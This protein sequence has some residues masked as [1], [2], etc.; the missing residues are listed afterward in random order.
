MNQLRAPAIPLITID[1]YFSIWSCSDNLYDDSPRHW[2]GVRQNMLGI[3]TIDGESKRFMGKINFDGVRH[4]DIPCL[5]QTDIKITPLKTTYVFEDEKIRLQLEFM[6]T[7]FLDDLKL[8]SRPV[9]YISYSVH[10][11]DNQEHI[12]EI[13]ICISAEAAVDQN[14]Q[15][16]SVKKYN[17]GACCGRGNKDILCISGDDRRIDWGWL[18]IFAQNN[19]IPVIM[20]MQNLALKYIR[21][22]EAKEFEKDDEFAVRDEWVSIG[23]KRDFTV[24]STDENGFI[25]IA[26][27]DIHS[28]MYFEKPIDAYYKK[29]GDTFD[30][31]CKKAL[32]EYDM[33]QKKANDFD[34]N[35]IIETNKI[36]KKYSDIISLSYRQA[37][38]AHKITWDG[39]EIQFFSKECFSNGCI[40]TVDVTYP[41]IP[42]FLLY[43]PDLVCGMLNPIFKYAVSHKWPYEF[44]PHDVG[45]YPLANGQVYGLDSSTGKLSL[46]M[47]MPIEECGNILIC[48]DALCRA[49][50]DFSYANKNLAIIKQWAEYLISHGFDPENQLCTDDFAG[51][52]A[53]N[54]NLSIK[55]ILGIACFGDILNR[56]GHQGEE[57]IKIARKFA[58]KWKKDAFEEDHYKLAFD[59]D[60]SWSIKYNLVWDKLLNLNIFDEDIFETELNYYAGKIKKYG[61]PLDSRSDYTKSDWQMWSILLDTNVK[62][63]QEIIDAMWEMLNDTSDRVPFTDWYFASTAVQRGFQ[64]RTVQAGLFIPL[65]KNQLE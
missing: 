7:L 61:L 34:Q 64:N 56:L 14:S 31:I 43:N 20:D 17:N 38:A 46:E 58:A 22:K 2:T 28:I 40:G 35:L 24:K 45:Q 36:C 18:H 51:H 29:D 25:C 50:H 8:C 63:Q 21:K 32:E 37:I 23:L 19:H 3:I 48:V 55:A 41:S 53:H 44:A 62:Y 16:V 27:D 59:L 65:L 57:Y 49:K 12:T 5:K 26:Y 6:S 52:L 30:S 39:E 13:F 11:K 9:S 47:Q 15:S 4:N 10:S 42:L 60:N 1:P 54:C 33:I